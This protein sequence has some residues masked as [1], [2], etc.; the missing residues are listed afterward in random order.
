MRV[1]IW[2]QFSSNHSGHFWVVGTFKTVEDA[3]KAY[4]ELRAMLTEIDRW[5][6]EHQG[7]ALQ[8]VQAWSP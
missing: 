7:E 4:D 6:R 1:S 3:Q 2:Q 5:H 8:P